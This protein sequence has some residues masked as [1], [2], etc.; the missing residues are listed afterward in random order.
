M[1]VDFLGRERRDMASLM[2]YYQERGAIS[3]QEQQRRVKTGMNLFNLATG[4]SSLASIAEM[5]L[6]QVAEVDK[7]VEGKGVE[8]EG[9]WVSDVFGMSEYK[10]TGEDGEERVIGQTPAYGMAMGRKYADFGKTIADFYNR[11]QATQENTI[12]PNDNGNKT[13]HGIS[14]D[15]LFDDGRTNDLSSDSAD[16]LRGLR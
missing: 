12:D 9:D 8:K 2:D 11:G 1:Q 10:F 5:N 4:L 6:E 14:D 15:W 16:Y 7:F 13:F 3:R